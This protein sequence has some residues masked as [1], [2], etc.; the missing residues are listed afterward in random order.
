MFP[1][2]G[3]DDREGR[4]QISDLVLGEEVMCFILRASL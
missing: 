4:H 3:D 2:S 1:H